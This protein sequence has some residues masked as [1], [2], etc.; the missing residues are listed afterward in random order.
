MKFAT[1]LPSPKLIAGSIAAL[2]LYDSSISPAKADVTVQYNYTLWNNT[3]FEDP[4]EGPV[5]KAALEEVVNYM[6]G[7]LDGLQNGRT[8]KISIAPDNTPGTLAGASALFAGST[9]S[10]VDSVVYR[11]LVLGINTGGSGY[12][13]VMFYNFNAVPAGDLYIGTGVP[14]P[15]QVDFRTLT[16]HELTHALGFSSKIAS[17]G[18]SSLGNGQYPKF[19]SFLQRGDNTPLLVGTSP[20]TFTGTTTSMTSDDIYFAGTNAV[21]ANGGN[22]IRM[23]APASYSS[24]SSLSHIS[25]ASTNLL[26]G[27]ELS[28]VMRPQLGN[29]KYQR[30]W[31]LIERGMLKDIGWTLDETA[32]TI[33][34]RTP[35]INATNVL[36]YS[37]ITATFDDTIAIGTGNISLVNITDGGQIDISVTDSSQVSVSGSTLTINPTSNLLDSKQYA[38]LID[39]GAILDDAGNSFAGILANTDWR[40]TV[41]DPDVID[42]TLASTSPVNGANSTVSANLVATFNEPIAIG[43][44]N[45]TIHNLTDN[46]N[47]VIAV[48][49]SSQVSVSGAV[50]TINPTAD[51]AYGKNNAVRIDATAIDDLAGNSYGGISDD[52]TWYFTLPGPG[53]V[54]LDELSTSGDFDGAVGDNL[55]NGGTFSG[56]WVN[57]SGRNLGYANNTTSG[58]PAGASNQILSVMDHERSMAFDLNYTTVRD[59]E[60][61][62]ISFYTIATAA[63]TDHGTDYGQLTLYYTSNNLRTGTVVSSIVLQGFTAAGVWTHTSVS[64]ASFSIEPGVGKKLF[65]KY[66]KTST[67]DNVAGETVGVD[68]ISVKLTPVAT[69]TFANWISGYPAVGSLTAASDDYDQDGIGNALENYFGTNPAVFSTGVVATGKSGNTF[70]FTHPLGANPASDITAAYRW[71]TDLASF[72][73]D[74]ATAGGS[75]VTFAQGTPSGGMVTVTATIT[76]T[77][78]ERLFVVVEANQN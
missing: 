41:A 37:N 32:P 67:G 12:D 29:G 75:T 38:V 15:T 22:R 78:P 11:N 59:A 58:R 52:L 68:N 1:S 39:A 20:P 43:S 62:D 47:T 21:A 70:T 44:G 49:D 24:G 26:F 4:V 31:T 71:S 16:L 77:V 2:A 17:N 57:T 55:G 45:I 5:R 63:S 28:H 65:L 30:T 48:T 8:L 42:P 33:A 27:D 35:A 3:G 7:Q 40:F 72:H 60:K 46:T 25:N 51:L 36:N 66:T 53:Y 19:S 61:Y 6:L 23:F 50:L 54:I 64:N 56:G 10:Y 14:G 18:S 34:S 74:G 73:A 76:G 69:N 9:N 13:I